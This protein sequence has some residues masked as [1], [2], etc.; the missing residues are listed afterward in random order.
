MIKT[1]ILAG[2]L[3]LAPIQ[4]ADEVENP[5]ITEVVDETSSEENAEQTNEDIV[6]EDQEKLIDKIKE[7]IDKILNTKLF[8]SM[9]FGAVCACIVTMLFNLW[10]SQT[11]NKLTKRNIE[12][13]ND[14]IEASKT[15]N[16]ELIKKLDELTAKVEELTKENEEHKQELAKFEDSVSNLALIERKIDILLNNQQLLSA[17]DDN[18]VSKGIAAQIDK[19]I[20]EIEGDKNEK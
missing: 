12:A 10:K 15:N 8:G 7:E 20:K 3:L 14:S 16:A 19:S 17:N 9:T 11:L 13:G 18:L 1:F 2:A 5:P 4:K 6:E